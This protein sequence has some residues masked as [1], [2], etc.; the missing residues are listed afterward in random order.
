MPAGPP[1]T[2]LDWSPPAELHRDGT[3]M[4]H[5]LDNS[6]FALDQPPT[7]EQLEAEFLRALA[8]RDMS[9]WRQRARDDAKIASNNQI[10]AKGRRQRVAS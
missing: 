3:P 1:E 2:G 10:R 6:A 8:R 7:S 9:V 4:Q 5:P